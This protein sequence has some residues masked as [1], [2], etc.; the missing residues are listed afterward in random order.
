MN[1]INKLL[2]FFFNSKQKRKNGFSNQGII[3][4]I[5]PTLS[6][7]SFDHTGQVYSIKKDV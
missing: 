4:L 6:A 2:V 3:L 7:M 1:K 5:I